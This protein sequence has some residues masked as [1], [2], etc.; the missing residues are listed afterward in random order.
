MR[1]SELLIDL[2]NGRSIVNLCLI[3]YQNSTA[4]LKCHSKFPRKI[5]FFEF[6]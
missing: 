1:I 6:S 5:G 4:G 2:M 3:I